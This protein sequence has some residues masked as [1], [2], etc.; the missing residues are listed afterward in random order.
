MPANSEA[1]QIVAK[2]V[3][4]PQG[5]LQLL[6]SEVKTFNLLAARK[7][8]D[9]EPINQPVMV[10]FD[11]VRRPEHPAKFFIVLLIELENSKREQDVLSFSISTTSA[12]EYRPNNRATDLPNDEENHSLFGDAVIIAINIIRGYLVNYLAPT[13]YRD[14]ILPTFSVKELFDKKFNAK[15]FPGVPPDEASESV[16][17]K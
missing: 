7:K 1:R 14:Y 5:D 12:F 11:V 4:M 9:Y 13:I 6:L 17:E 3:Q 16:D 15:V 2:T 10:D 8:K